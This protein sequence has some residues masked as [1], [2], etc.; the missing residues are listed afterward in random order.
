MTATHHT[1]AAHSATR[2]VGKV[3][4]QDG[5]KVIDSAG[6][7]FSIIPQPAARS[8]QPGKILFIAD[9]V[10]PCEEVTVRCFGSGRACQ[11]SP[12]D[13]TDRIAEVLDKST[14]CDIILPVTRY[15]LPVTRYPL[16]VT[17]YPLPVTRYP[18]PV[19]RYPLPVTRYPEKI[20]S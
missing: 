2:D 13:L 9:S 3:D 20:Y 15:P 14:A 16:P 6:V 12:A 1:T 11:K 7:A 18:L 10:T 4:T 19:T 5:A 8:P 17:R